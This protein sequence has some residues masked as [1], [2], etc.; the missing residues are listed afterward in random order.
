MGNIGCQREAHGNV[1][2]A[3]RQGRDEVTAE[4]R[5]VV[6]RYPVEEWHIVCEVPIQQIDTLAPCS[7]SPSICPITG[8]RKT[9]HSPLVF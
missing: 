1:D 7:K 4:V 3:D 5:P 6:L 9:I 2:G 8:I